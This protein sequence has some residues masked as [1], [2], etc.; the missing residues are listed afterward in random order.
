MWGGPAPTQCNP[1]KN[2]RR[3]RR[4]ACKVSGT[5]LGAFRLCRAPPRPCGVWR[6]GRC[7]SR[8][9]PG[10]PGGSGGQGP[11]RRPAPQITFRAMLVARHYWRTCKPSSSSSTP[12]S[13]GTYTSPYIKCKK[14]W[15]RI[16]Q[17]ISTYT[18]HVY[19]ARRPWPRQ[20]VS[21][22]GHMMG[23]PGGL[24]IRCGDASQ[25]L[26]ATGRRASSNQC[27][28]ASSQIRR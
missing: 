19:H 6:R 5:D 21:A 4:S 15:P 22:H 24:G 2:V 13:M 26:V 3:H 1:S 17:R 28:T 12:T 10:F 7:Y 25:V 9:R 16:P 20:G 27:H 23:V 8:P 18:F 14:T 11:P